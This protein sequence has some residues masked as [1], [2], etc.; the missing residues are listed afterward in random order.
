MVNC[1]NRLLLLSFCILYAH[2]LTAGFV[3]GT[4]IKLGP[5][6]KRIR[7]IPIEQLKERKFVYSY[8]LND[9]MVERIVTKT[10]KKRVNKYI[11]IIVDNHTIDASCDQLFFAPLEYAWIPAQ[12]LQPCMCLLKGTNEHVFIDDVIEIEQDIYVYDITVQHLHNFYVSDYDIVVHNFI[13]IFTIGCVWAIGGGIE[14]SS[15]YGAVAAAGVILGLVSKRASN[16]QHHAS[17]D[18]YYTQPILGYQSPYSNTP[19]NLSPIISPTSSNTQA[20]VASNNY[21]ADCFY[22]PADC[23]STLS[24]QIESELSAD[25][26]IRLMGKNNNHK[27]PKQENPQ[28]SPASGDPND[29]DPRNNNKFSEQKSDKENEK[30]KTPNQVDEEEA[31]KLGFTRDKNPPFKTHGVPAFKKGNRWITRDRTSHKGGRW[32]V[33]DQKGNR[34][35]TFDENLNY[36]AK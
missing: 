6:S 33:F 11:R 34:I 36:I 20:W 4:L 26:V 32:K 1:T 8:D 9:A 2:S 22:R 5:T 21:P 12:E 29:D 13:P 24:T 35:G 16:E 31:D 14:L 19:I 17:S 10:V 27:K 30:S 28:P 25:D 3:A 18:S 15:I 23:Q 7:Y